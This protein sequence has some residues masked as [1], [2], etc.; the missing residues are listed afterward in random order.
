MGFGYPI[1]LKGEIS[2]KWFEGIQTGLPVCMAAGLLGPL[3]LSHKQRKKY[4]NNYLPWV[5]KTGFE[6][7]F[8]MNIYYEKRW[9]QPV[10]E[11]LNELNIKPLVLP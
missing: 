6:A 1:S 11:I 3:Q 2:L 8:F 10:E 4:L 5:I 7:K 9:E